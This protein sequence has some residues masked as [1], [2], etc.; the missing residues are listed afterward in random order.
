M[1]FSHQW[2]FVTEADRNLG[3]IQGTI[4]I[5]DLKKK[6][7]LSWALISLTISSWF[8]FSF[9]VW[10][11]PSAKLTTKLLKMLEPF[12][13]S[14]AQSTAKY[15]EESPAVFMHLCIAATVCVYTCWGH[16]VLWG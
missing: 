1:F 7:S 5:R 8:Q 16:D 15:L 13:N 11:V 6:K 12:P 9:S 10:T 2:D 14:D 3:V 4:E